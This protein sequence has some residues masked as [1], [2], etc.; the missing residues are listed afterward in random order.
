MKETFI[1]RHI[2]EKTSKAELRPQE[3]IEKRRVVGRI[4]AIKYSRK[5]HR[6][7][8]RYKNRIKKSGQVRLV[9]ASINRNIPIT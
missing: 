2:V 5:G 6:D 7:R 9:Y 3:Q 8:N 4:Y 1:K